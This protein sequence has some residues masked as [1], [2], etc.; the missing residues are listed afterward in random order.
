MSIN[1]KEICKKLGRILGLRKSNCTF[2]EKILFFTIV[3]SWCEFKG[4]RKKK[5]IR[6]TN[7]SVD[8]MHQ[9]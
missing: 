7:L 4:F 6:P 2:I 9:L 3:V 8:Q 1:S 5:L